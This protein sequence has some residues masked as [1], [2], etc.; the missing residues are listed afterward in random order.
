MYNNVVPSFYSW[1]SPGSA[2]TTQL[3]TL[4]GSAF[5]PDRRYSSF[6]VRIANPTSSASFWI[7]GSD[8]TAT[9]RKGFPGSGDAGSAGAITDTV[10]WDKPGYLGLKLDEYY[11]A[12]PASTEFIFIVYA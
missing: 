2:G 6:T 3:S 8:V 5:S 11:I 10:V 4:M 1:T 9:N 12:Y 7:G